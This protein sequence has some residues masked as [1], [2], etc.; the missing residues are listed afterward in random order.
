MNFPASRLLP[1]AALALVYLAS[2]GTG[3]RA[4]PASAQKPTDDVLTVWRRT[5]GSAKALALAGQIVPAEQALVP[6]VS[7]RPGTAEWHLQVAAQLMRL[8]GSLAIDGNVAA[9]HAVAGRALDH[10]R[11]AEQMAPDARGVA[12]AL[13]QTGLIQEKVLLDVPAAKE[14]YRQAAAADSHNTVAAAAYQRL[15]KA[16]DELNRKAKIGG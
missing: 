3:G 1:C 7:T 14:S 12:Q 8:V 15:E 4:Q 10:L 2:F 13:Q 11:E 5:I 9:Q 6:F 16:T